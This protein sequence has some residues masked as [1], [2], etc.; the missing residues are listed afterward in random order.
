MSVSLSSW[1]VLRAGITTGEIVWVPSLASWFLAMKT[2][3][4]VSWIWS[5]SPRQRRPSMVQAWISLRL[6][7]E[8]KASRKTVFHVAYLREASSRGSKGGC[9]SWWR[10]KERFQ[11]GMLLEALGLSLWKLVM[12][13]AISGLLLMSKGVFP[14]VSAIAVLYPSMV[15]GRLFFSLKRKHIKL[16]ISFIEGAL[17]STCSWAHHL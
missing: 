16:Q 17:K 1:V 3:E 2:G 14:N 7:P 9:L 15:E 5:Q 10:T 6:L 11:V 13:L 12:S 4:G 8:A